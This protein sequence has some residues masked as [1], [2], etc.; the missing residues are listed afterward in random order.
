MFLFHGIRLLLMLLFE[1]L[2]ACC[3]GVLLCG[4]LM[5]FFLLS[6]QLLMLLLLLLGHLFL[7]R[8]IL[9]IRRRISRV[10]DSPRRRLNFFSVS[11]FGRC[12]RSLRP[13]RFR[14][15]RFRAGRVGG[16]LRTVLL[17]SVRA[18]PL[19]AERSGAL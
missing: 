3:I 15:I 2:I 1:L 19:F 5:I 17:F 11:R 6:R 4:A 18:A 13:I 14:T 7:F 10:R 8:L 16:S 9:L 12:G